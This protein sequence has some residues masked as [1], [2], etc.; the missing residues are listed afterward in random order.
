MVKYSMSEKFHPQFSVNSS[1]Y[2]YLEVEEFL[3]KLEEEFKSL[4]SKI[5]TLER[6]KQV[7]I[8]FKNEKDDNI[9]A[10]EKKVAELEFALSRQH[11]LAKELAESKRQLALA[12]ER[13]ANR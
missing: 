5:A 10:L 3:S 2:D 12:H 1:G 11:D 7:A 4:E 13:L 9:I 8:S 6:E